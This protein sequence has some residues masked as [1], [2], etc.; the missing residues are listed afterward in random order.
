MIPKVIHYCWFGPNELPESAKKYMQT[1]RK[2]LPDFEIKLW[3]EENF[4][5]NLYCYAREAYADGKFAFV[6]DICRAHAL[7]HEGGIYLDTDVEVLKNFAPLLGHTAFSGFEVSTLDIISDT[8][9]VNTQVGIIGAE[10]YTEWIKQVLSELTKLQYDNNHAVTINSIVDKIILKQGLILEDKFQYI[11]NYL[12]LYPS[13]YFS[14][15]DYQTGVINTSNATFCIHH[16]DASWLSPY[17]RVKNRY[18]KIF[19]SIFNKKLL[20]T[21]IKVKRKMS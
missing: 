15:K 11:D 3:N 2:C 8:K 7:Y 10:S 4:D 5:V 20:K 19:I 18:K 1:W 6:A 13:D 17:N 14:A 16:Y 21:I 12:Y 9:A